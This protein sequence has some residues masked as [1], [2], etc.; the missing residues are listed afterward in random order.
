[1][2]RVVMEKQVVIDIEQNYEIIGQ[3]G[4][5]AMGIVYKAMQK[6]PRRE[7]AIKVMKKKSGSVNDRRFKREMEIM[8]ELNHPNIAKIYAAGVVDDNYYVV[9]DYIAGQ[10]LGEYLENHPLPLIKKMKM[11]S[12][13]ASAIEYAHRKEVIHRDLKP[14]NI[15][16]G[17]GEH[18]YVIDFGLAKR[19]KNDRQYDL[20][21]TRELIGTPYY[22]APEQVVGK[23]SQISY[24]VDIYALGT[25]LYELLTNERMI[26]GNNVLQVLS[27]IRRGHI[28]APCKINKNIDKKLQTIWEKAS[29]RDRKYRYANMK[30]FCQDLERF[31][32]GKIIKNHYRKWIKTFNISCA[33]VFVAFMVVL[34]FHFMNSTS[35]VKAQLSKKE[36]EQQKRADDIVL[37]IRNK[38][39]TQ[40]EVDTLSL[41]KHL[42]LMTVVRALYNEKLYKEALKIIDYI[43]SHKVSGSVVLQIPYYKALILYHQQEYS[44]AID[45][46]SRIVRPHTEDAKIDYYQGICL[47]HTKR[48]K[49]ALF[50]LKRAEKIFV[51]D[52]QLLG[53]IT[54]IYMKDTKQSANAKKYLKR[55]VKLSPSISYYSYSLGKLYILENNYYEAFFY[56]QQAFLTDYN[57]EAAKL[58]HDIPYHEPLLRDD[59][60][61][62]IAH[63]FTTKFESLSP[64]LFESKWREIENLY[65]E[66]YSSRL[67]A[68]KNTNQSIT[69]FLSSLRSKEMHS[70]VESALYTARYSK[71]FDIEIERFIQKK[72]LS[73]EIANTI[74]TM[75]KNIKKEKKREVSRAIFYKLARRYRNKQK[76]G[77]SEFSKQEFLEALYFADNLFEKYL[78]LNGLLQ[79]HD[80]ASVLDIANKEKSQVLRTLAT[81]VLRENFL[82]QKN[83]V[84]NDLEKLEEDVSSQ[85]FEFLQVLTARS[86]FVPHFH[87]REDSFCRDFDKQKR[88]LVVS[89]R[90]QDF[91]YD[92]MMNKSLKVTITAA[93]SLHG[94]VPIQDLKP[95]WLKIKNVIEKA[96]YHKDENIRV[97][98]HYRLWSSY[99]TTRNSFYFPWF[100][101]GLNDSSLLVQDIV[102]SFAEKCRIDV[103]QFMPEITKCL[104]SDSILIRTRALFAWAINLKD[105]LLFENP[106]YKEV[107]KKFTALEKT[108]AYIF[109]FYSIFI[110]SRYKGRNMRVVAQAIAFFRFVE[111]GLSKLPVTTQCSV[112]Y[113]TSR[114]DIHFSVTR[115]KKIT[116]TKLLSYMLYQLH[117]ET[118]LGYKEK[119]QLAFL[120]PLTKRQKRF[121][122]QKFITHK[123]E[124][125]R[126]FA[127]SSYIALSQKYEEV[128]EFY[129]EAQKSSSI[130]QKQAIAL[131]LY[132]LF[133][134]ICMSELM[135]KEKQKNMLLSTE[136]YHIIVNGNLKR[137]SD[138]F[139]SMLNVHPAQKY[140]KKAIILDPNNDTY[141]FTNAMFFSLSVPEM[142]KALELNVLYRAGFC[143]ELYLFKLAEMIVRKNNKDL[144]YKYLNK[145]TSLSNFTLGGEAGYLYLALGELVFAQ[146]MFEK[147]L[148]TRANQEN[149][150]DE[151]LDEHMQMV[152]IYLNQKQ[153]TLARTLFYC[154]YEL[155]IRSNRGR[156]DQNTRKKFKQSMSNLYPEIKHIDHR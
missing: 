9:M 106:L 23:R 139:S 99:N 25:I 66:D 39:L 150:F 122:A 107:S 43:E 101:V 113:I 137:F 140:L 89:K 100:K 77:L 129:S 94:I 29:E 54:K 38:K 48:K 11:F 62:L 84:F 111:G 128:E 105:S 24:Q 127:L 96:L 26:T 110:D 130:K 109:S 86:M 61:R 79:L 45:F 68:N 7:V 28:T 76:S 148:L 118:N 8:G 5:G 52:M 133:Y 10:T 124:R 102:L 15:L 12:Q 73:V 42:Q 49:E 78:V 1:M 37:L 59:C 72:N 36:L 97:Y 153:F 123:N 74:L 65:A 83:E 67:M 121:I 32:E 103:K 126:K 22:M 81:V 85:D 117:E 135:A 156:R 2:N 93:T 60:Y 152:L 98:T 120:Q 16:V 21:K 71:E 143:Q 145:L 147:N 144:A 51:D 47:F 104:S 88:R 58:I 53:Y 80:F 91:L 64:L 70:Q 41:F 20:T 146:R 142:E 34:G 87:K 31:F 155:Q 30:L 125:V 35:T 46:F 90:E 115:M 151:V 138:Y 50:Y 134:N 63:V 33:F 13:V 92:L 18:L 108:S 56:L 40:I 132:Q 149:P 69:F 4:Q 116:D 6:S 136:P 119:T 154:L 55:C 27:N 44:N 131:G 82:A 112:S 95:K 19:I 75:Q 114:F 57:F 141:L 17:K 14:D 3:I